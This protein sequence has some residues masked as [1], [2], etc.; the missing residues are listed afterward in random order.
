MSQIMKIIL[1][2]SETDIMRWV[3]DLPFE[4]RESVA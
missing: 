2:F 3:K 1:N 4:K